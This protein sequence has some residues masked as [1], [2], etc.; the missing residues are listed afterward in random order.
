MT[1]HRV[2]YWV[3]QANF[4]PVKAEFFSASDRRLKTARYENFRQLGGKIR[5]TRL[6]LRDALHEGDESV[7]DY[8]GLKL[9]DLPD[10]VFTKD[11]LKRL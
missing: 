10:K 5:P 8:S 9:R 2:L 4:H 1:Y 6:V 3:K 11:Y 7:L